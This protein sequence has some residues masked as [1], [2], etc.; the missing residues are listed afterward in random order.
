[1]NTLRTIVSALCIVAIAGC[2][3]VKIGSAFDLQAFE[4]NVQRGVTTRDQVQAWLGA[5]PSRGVAVEPSGEQFEQWMYYYGEGKPPSLNEAT[6][7]S[8]Q[9]K[10]DQSGIVRAYNWS[11]NPP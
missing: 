9:V 7:K 2:A 8:L 1:M 6:W 3:S 11:S 4:K 10:F 5:P